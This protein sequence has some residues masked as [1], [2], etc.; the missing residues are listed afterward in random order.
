MPHIQGE[1]TSKDTIVQHLANVRFVIMTFR[2]A[3]THHILKEY[4]IR[5]DFLSKLSSSKIHDC[6]KTII[7]E[8]LLNPT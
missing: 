4:N 7:H 2:K 5:E 3:K 1:Y 6:N 8:T